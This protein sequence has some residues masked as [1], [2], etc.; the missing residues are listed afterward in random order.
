MQRATEHVQ[1]RRRAVPYANWSTASSVGGRRH[2]RSKWDMKTYVP[3]VYR[4]PQRRER[5]G[6]QLIA[7]RVC[8]LAQENLDNYR[9][10]RKV[11]NSLYNFF[12]LMNTSKHYLSASTAVASA[13]YIIFTLNVNQSASRLLGQR[14][15][16][17]RPWRRSDGVHDALRVPFKL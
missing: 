4:H 12:T 1:I 11:G 15:F 17:N 3:Y 14:L 8:E 16:Q 9:Y 6:E 5:P 2:F 13:I 10:V 7:T